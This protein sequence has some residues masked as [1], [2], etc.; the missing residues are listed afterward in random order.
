MISF[1]TVESTWRLPTDEKSVEWRNILNIG[2]YCGYAAYHGVQ[3]HIK[4]K[5]G[6][7]RLRFRAYPA[8][9]S[10]DSVT[11]ED[12]QVYSKYKAHMWVVNDDVN[13]LGVTFDDDRRYLVLRDSNYTKNRDSIGI[14]PYEP[15]HIEGNTVNY[16]KETV[17]DTANWKNNVPTF[18]GGDLLVAPD[19]VYR[20]KLT[21]RQ[22]L[23]NIN[24]DTGENLINRNSTVYDFPAPEIAEARD[25][26]GVF[27][28]LPSHTYYIN[29]GVFGLRPIV[30]TGG[31]D[32]WEEGEEIPPNT[33]DEFDGN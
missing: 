2:N 25:E 20:I 3:P 33:E 13:K 16:T 5:H 27:W 7:V 18:I 10:C 21:Y 17:R 14:A 6:L 32:G 9:Q 1:I 30:I 19:S 4:L 23:R 31:V 8:D 12:I 24:K 28:Y 29:I 15:L 11:I 22:T 26:N